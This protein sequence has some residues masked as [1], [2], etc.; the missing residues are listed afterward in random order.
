M[1]VH[2]GQPHPHE[3]C[4]CKP[5]GG[6]CPGAYVGRHSTAGLTDKR[7][8]DRRAERQDRAEAAKADL[9]GQADALV[10]RLRLVA[11]EAS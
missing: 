9:L 2:T 3:S 8:R 5:G 4:L 1:T 10:P 7:R 11:G 6:R